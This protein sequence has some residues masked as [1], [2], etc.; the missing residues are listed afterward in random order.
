[1]ESSISVRKKGKSADNSKAISFQEFSTKIQSV[2]SLK[3]EIFHILILFC[4]PCFILIDKPT[5]P[6]FM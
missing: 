1:M 2:A 6:Q 5:I 4:L 3:A